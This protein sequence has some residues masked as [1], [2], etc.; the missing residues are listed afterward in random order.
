MAVPWIEIPLTTMGRFPIMLPA[1]DEQQQILSVLGVLDDKIDSNRRLAALLEQTAAELFRAR[2]VDFVGVEEF[3]DS[4]IGR[5]PRGWRVAPFCDAIQINPARGLKR[6]ETGP[7]IE[8]SA[9][10]SLS[11]SG[12][13]LTIEESMNLEG[14]NGDCRNVGDEHEWSQ[15]CG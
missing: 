3:E 9:V 11:T 5:I 10:P 6:G 2:F 1:P 15:G 14:E 13:T 4:E 7:F 8:M 12:E